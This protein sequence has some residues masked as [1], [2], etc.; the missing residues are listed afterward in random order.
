MEAKLKKQC[1]WK[2]ENYKEKENVG[3]WF[4]NGGLVGR[5]WKNGEKHKIFCLFFIGN[6]SWHMVSGKHA[7]LEVLFLYSFLDIYLLF[8]INIFP[9]RKKLSLYWLLF[10]A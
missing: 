5:L 8:F 1:F 7:Y 9:L 4:M 6:G 10:Y 3:E 2:I